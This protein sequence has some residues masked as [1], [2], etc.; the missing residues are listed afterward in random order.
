MAY[1][2]KSQIKTNLYTNGEE[3]ILSNTNEDYIGYY[4]EISNG[5]KFTGKYPNDGRNIL[6]QSPFPKNEFGIDGPI[7]TKNEIIILNE[8]YESYPDI[9]DSNFQY[10]DPNS[11]TSRFIPSPIQ[12]FP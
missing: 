3:L 7:V 8:S 9:P 1:Y 6:L 10:L 12:S 4:Y 11:S 2:P 5:D